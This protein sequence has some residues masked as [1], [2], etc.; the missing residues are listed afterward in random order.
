MQARPELAGTYFYKTQL[1]I[2]FKYRFNF[3]VN[4]EKVLDGAKDVSEDRFG[5]MTHFLHVPDRS[6]TKHSS[7]AQQ[8]T[9]N[10]EQEDLED[11]IADFEKN[12]EADACD[13]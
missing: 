7:E 8:P 9:K 1:L 10:A 11:V 3:Y 13:D 2:G 5:N 6:F 12:T 4:D